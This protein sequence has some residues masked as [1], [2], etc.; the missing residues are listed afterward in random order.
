MRKRDK[1]ILDD[2]VR[3]RALTRNQIIDIHFGDLRNPVANA[4]AVMLRLYRQGYVE[5]TADYKQ[6]VYFPADGTLRK[7]SAKLRHFLAIADVYIR[8]RKL[9]GL[10]RF[11]V[12]PKYGKGYAEPD[13]FV[14]WR[15]SP[16]FIEVQRSIYSE[17][18][19]ADKVARYEALARSGVIEK[20]A[21]QPKG[22]TVM[23]AVIMLTETRYA[24]ESK[25][26]RFV[27]VADIG[28]LIPKVKPKI[29][30][31]RMKIS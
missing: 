20:E 16:F 2:L 7:D 27:Q 28:E 25:T 22:K 11:N 30:G 26:V 12:E 10:K 17:R 6:Y 29:E 21:W 15:G 19:I 1:A 23:P 31:I 4:N 18:Q 5:R 9:G 3:F 13:A 8:M 14:I 24:I